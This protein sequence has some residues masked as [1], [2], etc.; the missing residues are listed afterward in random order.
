MALG[1]TRAT[2]KAQSCMV[3]SA[4]TVRYKAVDPDATTPNMAT[5]QTHKNAH[6]HYESNNYDVNHNRDQLHIKMSNNNL[7]TNIKRKNNP[8]MTTKQ[9][10]T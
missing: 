2:A 5:Q 4:A 7:M 1:A 6:N 9:S 3:N 8:N 10:N